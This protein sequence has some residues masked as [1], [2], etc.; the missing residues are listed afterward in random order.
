MS[1]PSMSQSTKSTPPVPID[2]SFMTGAA[3]DANTHE[4]MRWLRENDPVYWS[5]V[6]KLWVITRFADVACV[7]KNQELFTS[8]K[9]VRPHN[10]VKIGLIDEPQPRHGQLRKLISKGFSPRMVR[11]LEESFTSLVTET[12]DAI[13][14]LGE[15]DFVEQIA[16]PLPLLM[17]A[18]MMGIAK[19]DR[20]DF[21]RWSDAMIAAEGNFDNKEIMERAAIAFMEYSAHLSGII[22]D[23]KK[24]PQEDLVSILSGADQSGILGKLDNADLP[25]SLGEEH[26]ALATNELIM[27]LV[28]LR[29]AGNETTRNALS[30]GMQLLIEHPEARRRLID[31]PGLIPQAIEEILRL[32]S[33]V[34]SFSR[35]CTSDTVLGNKQLR[36]GDVVLL[37]YPSANRDAAEFV[38]PDRFDIDRNP[39]HLAFGVGNHFCLGASLARMEL[40]VAFSHLL[41]RVPDM[42]YSEDGP[43]IENNPLVRTCSRMRVAYTPSRSK[44]KEQV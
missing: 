11:H 41:R 31:N 14:P 36:A 23:R 32:V 28:V 39:Q 44:L 15:C 29:V 9:G 2:V 3:W 8:A 10:P 43:H 42:R 26:E 17:I 5:A 22:E 25:M 6:D 1:D 21:H 16:V 4:R 35:T 37:V 30:G 13:A 33:P 19:K 24:N 18:E 27:L 38:D 34:R 40:H 7:S 12:L 20:R